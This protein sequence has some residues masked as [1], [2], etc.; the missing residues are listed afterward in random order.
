MIL[1]FLWLLI[2]HFTL[3]NVLI[4]DVKAVVHLENDHN[5]ILYGGDEYQASIY[6][7]VNDEMVRDV[8]RTGRGPGESESLS[9]FY[10]DVATGTYFFGDE[11]GQLFLFD[12]E[13][14]LIEQTRLG[15]YVM[16]DIQ[17]DADHI[18]ISI[19]AMIAEETTTTEP[20]TTVLKLDRQSLEIVDEIEI[21]LSD[22]ALDE[23]DNIDRI[24]LLYFSA[25][26]TS[27]N[28]SL[29]LTFDYFPFLFRLDEDGNISE[30]YKFSD[31][32]TLE[33]VQRQ[34]L[35]GTRTI[36]IC[37]NIQKIDSKIFCWKGN[38][39]QDIDYGWYALDLDNPEAPVTSGSIEDVGGEASNLRIIHG[40][41]TAVAFSPALFSGE[42][43][44]YLLRSEHKLVDTD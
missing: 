26:I 4:K 44:S 39:G 23:V 42:G 5:M 28:N 12:S 31:K 19:R 37:T 35:W 24:R 16:T 41:S 22:L 18:W 21:T 25:G 17:A 8:V 11:A 20:H 30:R 2:S 13:F 29:W 15:N 1:T 36:S 33:V 32:Q 3:S 9:S 10:H 6:D 40:E 14:E 43:S 34:G 7:A 38:A 27:Y